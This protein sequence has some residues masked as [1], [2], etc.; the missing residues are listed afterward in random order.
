[1]SYNRLLNKNRTFINILKKNNYIPLSD[2]EIKEILN[3][4]YF[5]IKTGQSYKL[6]ANY[7][8]LL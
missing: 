1:M 8:F 4:L 5:K 7:N 6:L 3:E 2:E